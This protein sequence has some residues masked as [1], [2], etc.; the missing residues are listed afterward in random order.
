M[1]LTHKLAVN[2]FK[3]SQSWPNNYE[4]CWKCVGKIGW[5]L[6]WLGKNCGF[7]LLIAYFWASANYSDQSLFQIFTDETSW[8]N[9]LHMST[10]T[11][12]KLIFGHS[13]R[14]FV[15]TQS[16]SSSSFA[17][18]SGWSFLQ[19]TGGDHTMSRNEGVS[20]QYGKHPP[21]MSYC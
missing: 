18:A 11:D 12:L 13:F 4:T 10:S 2:I 8:N 7:F 19:I 20:L 14:S 6:A 17:G 5:M 15:V 1:A 16:S 3:N 21:P 9:L